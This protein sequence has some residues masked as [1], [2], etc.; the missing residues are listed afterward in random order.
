M[1]WLTPPDQPPRPGGRYVVMEGWNLAL[2]PRCGSRS[3][4]HNAIHVPKTWQQMSVEEKKQTMICVIRHPLMRARSA[5]YRT[6]FTH[7]YD[8]VRANPTDLHHVPQA[9]VHKGYVDHWFSWN[10]WIAALPEQANRSHWEFDSRDKEK[11]FRDEE[12]VKIF[13]AYYA[14]DF[15]N[16][17]RY[18]ER[19]PAW[20]LGEVY[21]KDSDNPVR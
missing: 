8:M 20:D 5:L 4:Y 7:W 6:N 18:C 19:K 10:D 16:Y 2:T 3:G 17:N 13:Q 21:G 12:E 11:I 15:D 14:K 9:D 1:K